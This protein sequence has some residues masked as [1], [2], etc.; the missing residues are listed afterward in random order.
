[1]ASIRREI[2][3][4][5]DPKHVWEAIRDVGAVHTRLA[6]GF[7][8]DT[9]LE[10]GA[11]VVTFAN[12]LVAREL[13]VDVDD[14]SRRLVW[15]VVGG[16]PSHHNASLQ[17]FPEREGGCRVVWIADLLPNELADTIAG[18]IDQGMRVMKKTLETRTAVR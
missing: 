3:V 7:V 6:P 15:A 10:E 18:L 2:L 16:R 4:D 13:I 5:A 17:V 12:G 11:R 9:R 8:V 14:E 1:M